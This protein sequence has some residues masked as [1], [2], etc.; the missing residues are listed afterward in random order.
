MNN[1]KVELLNSALN[2]LR[3][4]AVCVDASEHRHFAFYKIKLGARAQFSQLE[5]RSREIALK[6]QSKSDPIFKVLREEGLIRLQVVTCEPKALPLIDLFATNPVR[7]KGILPMLLGETDD[8]KLLWTDM[9]NN[10]HMLV[11]GSTGS[12]KSVLLHNLIANAINLKNVRVFLVDPKGV[13]FASYASAELNS[14]VNQVVYDYAGTI[15]M[16]ENLVELMEDRYEQLRVLGAQSI[17]SYTDLFDPILVIIDEV[18]DLMMKDGKDKKF[19]K[20]II[21]LAQKSRAAGIFLVLATQHPSV[22]VLTGLI[23]ANFEA[24]LSCKVSSRVDSQVILDTQGAECLV[25]RGDAII[26]NRDHEMVRFQVAFVDTKSVIWH[27]RNT[28]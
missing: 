14:I 7:P 2:G 27:F 8:G 15:E 22:K 25:G 12:G 17:E 4:D 16:L 5:R 18:S 1:E 28:R 24:R 21:Q 26:R 10:P 3:I 13:E 9:A 11:A 19:E 23:K 6:L 20:L